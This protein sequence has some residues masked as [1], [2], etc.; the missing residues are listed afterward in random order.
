M[1]FEHLKEKFIEDANNLL[2]NLDNA[3]VVFEKHPHN[4]ECIDQI[5]RVM[6]TLKGASGMYGF[7]KIEEITHE[8]ENIFDLINQNKITANTELVDLTLASADHIRNLLTDESF[9]SLQNISSHKLLLEN[10]QFLVKQSGLFKDQSTKVKSHIRG[11]EKKLRTWHILFTPDDTLFF[12]AI[13]I[14][15][16]YHDL[17]SLGECKFQAP[18]PESEVLHWSIYLISD[19]TKDEID[20]VFIFVDDYFKVKL[21][22]EFNIFEHEAL[23]E[24]DKISSHTLIKKQGKENESANQTSPEKA[25]IKRDLSK[26]GK[27]T[28]TRITVDAE[29]LDVLMYLVSEL[30]TAKSELLLSINIDDKI[31]IQETAEKIDKLSK[32]FRDNALDIRLVS[33]NEVLARFNRL[34]R[35]LCHTLGKHVD[36]ETSGEDTELDK[37]IIDAI[38]EPLM[39]LVRNCIDHGIESPEE[40]KNAGKLETGKVKFLAFKSG[41]FVFM[42]VSDD[43]KGID[44]EKVKSKAIEK[45]IIPET[46]NLTDI[47][48]W[49]LIFL[50]GFSTAESL[51]QVSG[52]G[53]GMDVV[54]KKIEELRGEISIE[55]LKGVGTTFTIKLQQTVSI[56]DTLLV[57]CGN[58]K[59]A[60]PLEDVENCAI[61]LNSVL[62]KTDKRQIAYKDELIPY[63]NLHK[64]FLV[65]DK[66]PEKWKTVIIKR[67]DKFFAVL[68]DD[69]IGEYQAVIKPLGKTFQHQDFVSGAS[70][71][72]DGSIALLID[73]DK[74]K[75]IIQ[76]N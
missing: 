27:V 23:K 26:I 2:N 55:S 56:I 67:Q 13:N 57:R 46:A 72:G 20:D 17:F 30:V 16:V 60:I 10:I 22:A 73:S 12:R 50:P 25:E 41:N 42:Q 24:R 71:L 52:R 49:N 40:R 19:K 44:T 8:L 33:L 18:D 70:I 1:N 14:L 54:K 38:S 6:H 76:N 9:T 32:N 7:H 48:I 43:G 3:L 28:S 68:T 35:D 31:K 39:H 21:I 37:N 53:V 15:S 74:L 59:L 63:I 69:I 36:F 5:F 4:K 29:K 66:I 58:T 11:N 64:E 65:D 62:L 61:L 47:D 75:K 51:T 34:V 45:G